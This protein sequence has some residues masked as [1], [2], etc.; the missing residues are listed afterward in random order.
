MV[1]R[2][3]AASITTLAFTSISR[4]E[5]RSTKWAPFTSPVFLSTVSWRTMAFETMSSFPVAVLRLA[6]KVSALPIH[7]TSVMDAGHARLGI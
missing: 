7:V 4:R 6:V 5:C 1:S 2:E 3:P